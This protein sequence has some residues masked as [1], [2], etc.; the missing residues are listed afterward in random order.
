MNSNQALN[1]SGL[2]E[3]VETAL[4]QKLALNPDD[5]KTLEFLGHNYRM[6]GDL[7]TAARTLAEL[8]ELQPN[9]PT[10]AYLAAVLSGSPLPVHEPRVLPWP[11]PFTRIENF[12][13]GR[14]RDR[15][16]ELASE[17]RAEF[18]PMNTYRPADGDKLI[19]RHD[20]DLRQQVGLSG[21]KEVEDI[22]KPAVLDILPDLL[23]RLQLLPFS[24][25]NISLELVL[26]HDGHF[27]E[28]HTDDLDGRIKVSFAY[29]FHKQPKAFSGGDLLLYDTEVGERSYNPLRYTRIRHEDNM[30]LVFPSHYSHEITP[31]SCQSDALE[32][33]RFTVS[34]RVS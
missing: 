10:A 7:A 31:V 9:H 8:S 28:V 14:Q 15:L 25:R 19:A 29:Y 33:G 21:H 22:V 12:L 32:D 34:G 2:L 18:A 27:G 3:K 11:T 20:P 13:P 17:L 4:K 23:A 6:Q 16:L 5:E 30:L 1:Q 26:S 24:I